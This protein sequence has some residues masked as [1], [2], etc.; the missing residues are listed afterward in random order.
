MIGDFNFPLEKYF[1]RF[2]QPGE[3]DV[4]TPSWEWY[5]M[6]ESW[7]LPWSLWG[8]TR[9]MRESGRYYLPQEPKETDEQ[10]KNR[11]QRT[12]LYNAYKKSIVSLASQPFNRPVQVDNLPEE[13]SY[14]E[15]DADSMGSSL[16][17]IAYELLVQGLIY[18]KFHTLTDYPPVEGE[19]TLLEQRENKIRPYINVISPLN[20]IGWSSKRVGG[21]DITT[22]VRVKE[23]AIEVGENYQEHLVTYLR[24]YNQDKVELHSYKDGNENYNYQYQE[25]FSNTL[26]YIPLSTGYVEKTGTMTSHPPL[27]DLAWMNLRHW[28]S[29]SD[30]NNILHV[31]RVPILFARGFEEGELDNAEIGASR[32]ITTTN[33]NGAMEYIE[34]SGQAIG[35]GKEDLEAIENRMKTL[36]SDI[37]Y[38]KAVPRQTAT[39]RSID[40]SETLSTMSLTIR[41]LEHCLETAIKHAG[42]WINVD[43]SN[44]KV[45]IGEDL[46][47][48][49]EAN[50]TNDLMGMIE[51]EII[52]EEQFVKEM[53]RRG[54]LSGDTF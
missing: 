38:D 18:G 20:L 44:V 32:A 54:I 1:L 5:W 53:K 22:E 4:G 30:Q 16:T 26:G 48:P 9:R 11:L 10:Y 51:N 40:K 14:L 27:E 2:P 42:D 15:D 28:Q 21:I 52:T 46:S 23:T 45:R 12:F 13:L 19:I 35:S 34:H 6:W 7:R 29:S 31:A 49:V 25:T 50:S 8:G 37:L 3:P 47:L 36:G 17:E 41:E 24:L 39:A 33:E 43:A